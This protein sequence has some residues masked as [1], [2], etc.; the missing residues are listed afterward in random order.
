MNAEPVLEEQDQTAQALLELM[1]KLLGELHPYET[2]PF[3]VN[4]DSSFDA[5]LRLDSLARVELISRLEQH[6]H[7]ALPQRVFVEA[8]TA[9][10]LLRAISSARGRK[11]ISPPVT[12]TEVTA[13]ETENLPEHATTLIE[14]LEW[15]VRQHPERLHIRILVDEGEE[16]T[17]TYEQLWKGAQRL[18]TGLQQKGVQPGET[19]AIMLPTGRDYF[20]SFYAILLSGA[21]PVPIYP[22]VRRTQLEDHLRRHSGI[23]NNCG[24]SILISVAEAKL[25]ATLLKSQVV[26]LREMVTVSELASA[27]GQY[28]SPSIA[29]QDIA[30]LQ[31]T[32]GSTGNPK[33]VVLTHA[34]LLANI[35]VMGEAIK[36]DSNDVFISW[37]PLY[38]DMGLIGAWFGSLYFSVSLVVMSPLSFLTRPQRWLWAIHQYR[39]TLSASPN[40]GYE[41]CLKRIRDEDLQGLD[42]SSWRLAFNGAEPVSPDTVSRFAER[43]ESVGVRP[44]IIMPVY[45]LAESAVGLA[46]PPLNRRPLI[47]CVQREAFSLTGEAVAAD[48]TDKNALC[49]VASGQPLPGHQVRIVDSDGRELPERQQGA[50]QFHGPSATTGYYRNPEATKRLFFQDWLDSGDLAYIAEG[51]IYIT[52]RSKD[53]IIRAGR[54]IYPHELEEAIGNV[55]G[56]RKGCVVA[57]G[58][59]DR[60]TGT[61]RLVILVETREK[62][63]AQKEILRNKIIPIASDLIGLPPDEVILVSPHTI[64]K[65]SSG[66]IRRSACRDLYE[67]GQLDR[68]IKS[69]WLQF[70]HTLMRSVLP[71]WHR[72]RKKIG[73]SLYAAYAWSLFGVMAGISWLAVMI[74]PRVEW[75][76]RVLHILGRLLAFASGTK[77]QVNGLE[78][79]PPTRQTCVFVANHASYL[80]S[81]ALTAAI[82][83]AFAFVAKVELR[84]KLFLRL[85]LRQLGVEFVKRFNKKQGSIDTQ[86]LARVARHN[87][88][89]VFF[90]EGTFG[91]MPGLMDFYMGAFITSA[92]VNLPV[93]PIAIRG[94][95]SMLRSGSWFPRRG[96]ITI[97]IGQAISVDS[98][99]DVDKHDKWRVALKL[100]D[101][102]R[103]HILRYCGEPELPR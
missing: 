47:D 15:H 8:E 95:R 96:Y 17:L 64:L 41:L 20:F 74:L 11:E 80:D 21:I 66:K 50:L 77:I 89:L 45:G 83:R 37:L 53:V 92:E 40:F 91:R 7:V 12:I 57:F 36:A 84:R 63:A 99:S 42:L 97:T 35:R 38:H 61:E 55:P 102:A 3:K 65:T 39:G 34:N 23:L 103:K 4:L 58:T 30:F 76:W 26:S 69:V 2:R 82:P 67:Y 5:D 85:A 9:R 31:Y 43:F 10:D 14:V 68:A 29:A 51:D 79:L 75:R 86:R 100:R 87:Q 90:P 54:N 71:E 16:D 44:E 56:V 81:L 52:G 59:T 46:F 25:I 19:V 94:T 22:P 101:E 32:S 73:T 1:Q 49:F 28:R 18:A 6:F 27:S 24:A 60:R 13:G 33:G 78:N 93:V 98:L 70:S 72:L 48:K 62:A 88:S